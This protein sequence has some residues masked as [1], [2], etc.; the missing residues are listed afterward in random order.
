MARARVKARARD[1]AVLLGECKVLED[2]GDDH[3]EDH[4]GGEHL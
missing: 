3:V 4:E 2:D 1:R